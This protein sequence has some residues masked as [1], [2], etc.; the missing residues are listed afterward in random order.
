MSSNGSSIGDKPLSQ[1]S[2]ASSQDS[3]TRVVQRFIAGSQEEPGTSSSGHYLAP[4]PGG[5]G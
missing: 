3:V 4:G 1:G 2:Q 5:L